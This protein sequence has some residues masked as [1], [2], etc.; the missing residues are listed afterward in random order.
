MARQIDWRMC[1]SRSAHQES[2][3]RSER[4]DGPQARDL[5]QDTA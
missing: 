5:L 3:C 2:E 4:S 1:T